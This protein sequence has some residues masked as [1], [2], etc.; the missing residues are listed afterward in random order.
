[1]NGST[2]VFYILTATA[3]YQRKI[4][5]LTSPIISSYPRFILY[6]LPFSTAQLFVRDGTAAGE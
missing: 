5:S 4:N 6:K 1:M 3:Y 2:Y